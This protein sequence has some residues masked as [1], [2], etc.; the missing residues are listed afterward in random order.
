MS[1]KLF[2]I[3]FDYSVNAVNYGK[4]K[5]IKL[6]DFMKKTLT[7]GLFILARR[8][9][10]DTGLV[11]IQKEEPHQSL[12]PATELHHLG[13]HLHGAH[14]FLHWGQEKRKTDKKNEKRSESKK[15]ICW[16]ALQHKVCVYCVCEWINTKFHPV[17]HNI[18]MYLHTHRNTQNCKAKASDPP[19]TADRA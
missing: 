11:F 1:S 13:T 19:V 17:S 6:C 4:R 7:L 3:H 16:S 2:P 5:D 12:G 14:A 10:A 18:V 9:P 15:K 8:P